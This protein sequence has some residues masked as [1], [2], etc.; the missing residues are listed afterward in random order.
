MLSLQ[1]PEFLLFRKLAETGKLKKYVAKR[2]RK[3]VKTTKQVRWQWL[4]GQAQ[5]EAKAARRIEE[6]FPKLFQ[7]VRAIKRGK[8]GNKLFSH[9]LTK[10]ESR[11]VIDGVAARIAQ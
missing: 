6:V 7:L 5:R 2:L 11:L 8:N 3:S 9:L 1:D 10:I 4:F